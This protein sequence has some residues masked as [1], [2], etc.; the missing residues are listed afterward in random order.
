MLREQPEGRTRNL[1]CGGVSFLA[2][3][4]PPV[5]CVYLHL[6]SSPQTLGYAI[7]ARVVRCQETPE[8]LLEVGAV[9]PP[10]K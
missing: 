6:H 3:K 2:E 7:L 8:G 4:P 5:E 9:F 1:S 10:K